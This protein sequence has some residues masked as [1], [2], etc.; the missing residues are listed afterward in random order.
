MWKDAP[1][2]PNKGKSAPKKISDKENDSSKSKS[3]S[4][5]AKTPAEPEEEDAPQSSEE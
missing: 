1:E 4:K 3:R 5:K 2:N